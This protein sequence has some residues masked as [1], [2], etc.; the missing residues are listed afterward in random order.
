MTTPSI[1]EKYNPNQNSVW[2]Y[3]TENV[4]PDISNSGALIDLTFLERNTHC[5]KKLT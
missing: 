3:I 4:L 2:L 5:K 1:G